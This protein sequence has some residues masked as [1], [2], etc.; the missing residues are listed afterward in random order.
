[1]IESAKKTPGKARRSRKDKGLPRLN[2][3]DRFALRWIGQQYAIRFDQL[4]RL[5]ARQAGAA[6][7]TPGRLSAT[8][9]CQIIAR[10]E[11]ASL[12]QYR[13]ILVGEPGWVWLTRQGLF[14]SGLDLRYYEPRHSALSHL[15]FVNQCRLIMEEEND[16]VDEF[17]WISE[18]EI[19]SRQEQRQKGGK[20]EHVPDAVAEGRTETIEIEIELT[21]KTQDEL[22]R[23]MRGGTRTQS[24]NALRYFASRA[25]KTALYAALNSLN[26]TARKWIDIRD[27]R[28]LDR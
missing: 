4:Q 22:V 27:L 10:W 20:L 7:K 3:R 2:D 21:A 9:A 1:M 14:H 23:I 24:A 5:L 15:F 17:R 13:K 28:E 16:G 26:G 8:R 12:A 25:A 6:T 18:R 19:R 11:R